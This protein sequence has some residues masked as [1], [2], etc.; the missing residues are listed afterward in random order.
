M[1]VESKVGEGTAFFINLP[2]S[3]VNRQGANDR[4]R[5]HGKD[6]GR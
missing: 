6:F 3:Q 1:V 4:P 2:A 5:V